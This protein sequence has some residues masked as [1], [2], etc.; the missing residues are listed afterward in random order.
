MFIINGSS[1]D[2]PTVFL[3]MKD[4]KI[5]EELK[6][7]CEWMNSLGVRDCR[8]NDRF[9]QYLK[10]FKEFDGFSSTNL[11]SE[12]KFGIY[13]RT[14]TEAAEIIRIHRALSGI[15]SDDFINRLKKITSGKLFKTRVESDPG[16]DYAFELSVASRFIEGGYEVNLSNLADVVARVDGV[17]VFVE[18]K[19]IQSDSKIAKRIKE[20]Q[21]QLETRFNSNASK[22]SRGIIAC[23]ISDLVNPDYKI[24]YYSGVP[25]IRLETEPLIKNYVKN[26]NENKVFAHKKRQIAVLFEAQFGGVRIPRDGDVDKIIGII[27]CRGAVMSVDQKM[28]GFHNNNLLMKFSKKLTSIPS[29]PV[30]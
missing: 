4:G 17:D 27:A 11:P 3:H 7:A 8:K 29:I 25:S 2:F 28:N 30:V 22:K 9:S 16:R 23:S 13:V 19:R 6:A 24:R 14:H 26:L 21:D 10:I 20:A 12:E 5:H 15:S 18:C 1:I